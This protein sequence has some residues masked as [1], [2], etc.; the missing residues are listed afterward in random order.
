[1]ITFF[2]IKVE[3]VSIGNAEIVVVGES[4]TLGVD[5]VIVVVSAQT[6]DS[7]SFVFGDFIFIYLRARLSFSQCDDL[8]CFLEHDIKLK[9]NNCFKL[10]I[11]KNM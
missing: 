1:M 2:S 6:D 5:D 9:R 8:H 11:S 4:I 10:N 3:E 7:V